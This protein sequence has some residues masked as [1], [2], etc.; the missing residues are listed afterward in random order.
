MGVFS[1]AATKA[2][3]DALRASMPK[4]KVSSVTRIRAMRDGD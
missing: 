1:I 3:L 4:M 2:K